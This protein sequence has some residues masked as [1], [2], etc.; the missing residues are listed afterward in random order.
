MVSLMEPAQTHIL[1]CQDEPVRDKMVP[2]GIDTARKHKRKFL[3][4]AAAQS[5]GHFHVHIFEAE[6]GGPWLLLYKSLDKNTL[7][8]L[9]R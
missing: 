1:E 5:S 7:S 4:L 3:C 2:R 9:K 6:A 8:S